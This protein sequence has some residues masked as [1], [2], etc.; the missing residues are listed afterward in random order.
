MRPTHI[1]FQVYGSQRMAVYVGLKD[2]CRE[3][4]QAKNQEYHT[5]AYRVEQYI[6]KW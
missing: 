6:P 5:D 2:D 3:Y 1:V 4:A